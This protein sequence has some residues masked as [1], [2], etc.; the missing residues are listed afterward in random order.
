MGREALGEIEHHTLLA[1]TRLGDEAYTGAIVTELEARTGRE[2]TLAAVYI[3][4]TR[5][6]RKGLVVSEV[7][8]TAG[9]RDRRYFAITAEGLDRLRAARSAYERLWEGLD[10]RLG[11]SR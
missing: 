2:H 8:E 10:A 1:M 3:A 5:L 6:E 9:R 11:S 4:L 7:K